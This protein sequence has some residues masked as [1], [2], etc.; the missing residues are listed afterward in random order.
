[1]VILFLSSV[2]SCGGDHGISSREEGEWPS[3]SKNEMNMT[4]AIF[5]PSLVQS[6]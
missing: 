4:M 6:C 2:K 5:L 1:M 3:S